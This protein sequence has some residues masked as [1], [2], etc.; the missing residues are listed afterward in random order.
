VHT[1]ED[2][3]DTDT[4]DCSSPTVGGG[5]ATNVRAWWSNFARLFP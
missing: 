3:L 4:F 1:P 5:V 2:R